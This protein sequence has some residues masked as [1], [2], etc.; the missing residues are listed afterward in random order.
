M[1][2]FTCINLPVSSLT[3]LLIFAMAIV[4]MIH[5]AN[6]KQIVRPT[7]VARQKLENVSIAESLSSISRYSAPGAKSCQHS[8]R[9]GKVTFKKHIVQKIIEV[10]RS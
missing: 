8:D 1:T 2:R 4:S 10:R 9:I 3:I 6:C 5:E 7:D